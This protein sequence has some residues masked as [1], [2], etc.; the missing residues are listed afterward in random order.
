MGDELSLRARKQRRT[1]ETI[2]DAAMTLFAERGFDGVTVD[3]IAAKAE[4]GRTTFFRYFADKQEVLFADDDELQRELATTVD[5]AARRHAPIE[6]SLE[7]AI[8]IARD[9]L[10]ALVRVALRRPTWLPLR[11]QLIDASNPLTARSLTKEHR[12]L[13]AV[14]DLLVRHGATTETA[15]LAAELAGACYRT[16]RASTPD[17][18]ERLPEAIDAAYQ[19]LASLNPDK[20]D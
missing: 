13:H 18:P 9:G 17:A 2:I 6:D 16:A 7:T 11:Q 4:V 10:L 3:E 12:Y 8:T 14:V 1:R 19:R 5:E 20:L 15:T